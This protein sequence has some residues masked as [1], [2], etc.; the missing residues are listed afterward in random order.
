MKSERGQSTKRRKTVWQ[1]I[2]VAKDRRRGR[3][4][5]SSGRSGAGGHRG[6]GPLL[7]PGSK[8]AEAWN[9][10][11]ITGDVSPRS[12]SVALLSPHRVSGYRFRTTSSVSHEAPRTNP[13]AWER[14]RVLISLPARAEAHTKSAL[15]GH[16]CHRLVDMDTPGP[17]DADIPGKST[18]TPGPNLSTALEG[19]WEPKPNHT[20]VRSVDRPHGDPVQ[21][22]AC[23]L[24]EFGTGKGLAGCGPVS[25]LFGM[26]ASS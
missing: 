19:S 18:G 21:P 24:V 12:Q 3:R 7:A 20:S 1:R 8:W 9:L 10:S 2:G 13:T 23:R 25:W 16:T 26:T 22:T 14:H 5:K 17:A 4:R 11:A 15:H 6:S